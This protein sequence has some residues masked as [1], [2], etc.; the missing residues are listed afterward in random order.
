MPGRV[1]RFF[2]AVALAKL[3]VSTEKRYID[4]VMALSPIEAQAAS[5][6]ADHLY[7]FLPGEAHPFADQ[8]TS[9]EGIA[10][11]VSVG[12]YWPGGSKLPALTQLMSGVLEHDRGRFCPL[13]I[14]IVRAGVRYRQG[15]ASVTREEIEGLNEIVARV[16]F[17]IPELH[18]PMFLDA[19]P[20]M[21][22][23]QTTPAAG[24]DAAV[25][26][27]LRWRLVAITR[28][29][30]QERGLQFEKFLGALF[31]AYDLAPRAAFRLVGDQIDGSVQFQGQTY[32]VEARW[33]ADKMGE[34]DLLVFSGKVGGKARWSRGICL[35]V[36]GFTAEG[37]EG[38]ARGKS[39]NIICADGLDLYHVLGGKLDLRTAVERKARAAVETNRA[40]VPVRDLFPLVV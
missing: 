20:R 23:P 2:P 8:G 29:A 33:Q 26:A 16:G 21:A 19:L 11:R 40:F 5:E 35:S 22:P 15:K 30:P 4:G 34:A 18:D 28:V 1:D 32:L 12:R 24:P 14:E 13:I 25:L 6:L 38:F 27:D 36:S 17:K 31:E 10:I 39:T 37:L 9:F 7:S 3:G